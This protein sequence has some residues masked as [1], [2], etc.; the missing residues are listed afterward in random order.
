VVVVVVVVLVL[1][2]REEERRR[3]RRRRRNKNGHHRWSTRPLPST[4]A[5]HLTSPEHQ[6]M[7]MNHHYYYSSSSSFFLVSF[8]QP[9]L[10]ISCPTA[11]VAPTTATRL[12]VTVVDM[13][14]GK[15]AFE[16]VVVVVKGAED[17][18]TARPASMKKGTSKEEQERCISCCTVVVVR[19]HGVVDVLPTKGAWMV[20]KSIQER[21]AIYCGQVDHQRREQKGFEKNTLIC[22]ECTINSTTIFL[23]AQT[24]CARPDRPHEF[25]VAPFLSS[26]T[27]RPFPNVTSHELQQ[28]TPQDQCCFPE[29]FSFQ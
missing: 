25:C 19:V 5:H 6:I 24:S 15:Q 22:F 16:V 9:T 12:G 13:I 10:I 7:Q 28:S 1:A 14:V 29:V 20:N 8:V 27:P 17:N 11:P 23:S 21:G 2:G 3:R 4:I 26:T 18:N